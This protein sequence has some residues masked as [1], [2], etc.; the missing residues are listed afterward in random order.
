MLQRL[1]WRIFPV[2]AVALSV[3]TVPASAGTKI[4]I[5]TDSQEALAAYLKGRDLSERLQG[6]ESVQH[7]ERAVAADPEFAMAYVL[8]SFVRPTPGAFFATFDTARALADGVSEGERLWIL[9]VEAGVHG[10]PPQQRQCYLRLVELYPDDERAHSLLGN[11]HFAQQQYAEAI[12][13]YERSVAIA[14]EFS[15]PYN[16]MGYAYRFSGNFER[17]SRAFER[18][19]ELIPDDPNPHDSYAELLLKMGEHARSIA[20]YRKALELNPNFVASHV[21]I[22]CN[23]NYLG[24]HDRARGQAE[25][26]LMLAR[27]E[28]ERRAAHFAMS[29]SYADQGQ[30]GWALVE[31]HRMYVLAEE[32]DD[33][34]AMAADLTNMG[35]I[36]LQS[37]HADEALDRFT[38][39]REVVQESD[40]SDPVKANNRRLS[41]YNTARA[42]VGLGDLARATE[43]AESFGKQAA[44][45]ENPFQIRLAHEL[46]GVIALAERRYADARDNL[47]LANQQDPYNAYRMGLAYLGSGDWESAVEWLE[48]AARFNALNSLNQGF[49]RQRALADLAAARQLH[50]ALGAKR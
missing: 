19:I 31:Q 17:A 14:P 45:V 10:L 35:S 42:S 48:R 50:G 36:L 28:G 11:H 9:G 12:A 46:A 24:K 21:G 49:I 7:F 41:L 26:L 43:L 27:N 25:K 29:V 40:L 20:A 5:T 3:L 22:A 15:Q 39:A 8:L 23:L 1:N 32:L 4:P 16:Q 37:G 34:A 47:A 30:L 13:C 6:Q 18:Y 2:L 38:D 33:P 44:A